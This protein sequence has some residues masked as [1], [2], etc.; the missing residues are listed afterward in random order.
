MDLHAG[1]RILGCKNDALDCNTHTYTLT[2]GAM[3]KHA[4]VYGTQLKGCVSQVHMLS[5]TEPHSTA[6]AASR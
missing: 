6:T 3:N 4:G 2:L 5:H 1:G